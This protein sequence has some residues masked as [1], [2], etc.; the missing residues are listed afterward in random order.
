MNKTNR[1][2]C[3]CCGKRITIGPSGRV[4]K[5]TMPNGKYCF[6]SHGVMYSKL[7]V[8]GIKDPSPLP[9]TTPTTEPTHSPDEPVN[10]EEG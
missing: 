9:F 2:T 6:R 10:Y 1:R 3:P 8:Y 7:L 4:Y 5:H